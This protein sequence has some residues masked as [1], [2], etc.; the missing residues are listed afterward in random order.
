MAKG[1]PG[2]CKEGGHAIR[3]QDAVGQG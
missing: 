1:A 2:F 3:W